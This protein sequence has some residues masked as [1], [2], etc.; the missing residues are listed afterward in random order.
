MARCHRIGQSKPVV[1]YRLCTKGT[2]DEAIIKRANAK[3]FLEKAVIAKEGALVNSVDGLLKLKKLLEEET[4]KVVDAK[5]EGNAARLLVR[6]FE[7]FEFCFVY[8]L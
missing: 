7:F 4:F 3:R 1:V 5:N 6:M 2:V 8:V